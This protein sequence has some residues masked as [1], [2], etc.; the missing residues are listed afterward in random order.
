M[1]P[2]TH[3]AP[4]ALPNN[5]P[6]LC[7]IVDVHNNGH[8]VQRTTMDDLG[9]GVDGRLHYDALKNPAA[10]ICATMSDPSGVTA[11]SCSVSGMRLASVPPVVSPS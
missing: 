4:A 1:I 9:S 10:A 11:K 5:H 7:V 8:A 2:I 6:S 3:S